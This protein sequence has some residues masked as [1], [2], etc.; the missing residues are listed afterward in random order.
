MNIELQTFYPANILV[1][2]DKPENVKLLSRL[3]TEQ[4]YKVR[5]VTNGEMALRAVQKMPP[6]LIL[7]DVKM[8]GLNGY[9]VCQRLK[10]IPEISQIPII[11][12][13]A[14]EDS[15]DKLKA[16]EAGGVD[17]IT[18]PFQLPEVLMRVQNQLKIQ[19][20]QT[21]IKLLN[22][23][24][25]EQVRQRT[26][27]LEQEIVKHEETQE[28]LRRMA[29]YDSLTGLPNRA[30]FLEL[31]H[32]AMEKVKRD[33][34]YLF[35]VLFLDCDRFKLINDSLG[36]FVGDQVLQE[37]AHRLKLCLRSVDTVARLGGDEFIILLEGLKKISDTEVI[38]NRIHQQLK[39]PLYL[40]EREI[41]M[42]ASIGIVLDTKDY[43]SPDM[44]LRD[45]DTAMYW[46]KKT[47]QNR[48]QIFKPEMHSQAQ[49]AL[50]LE[51]DL[52]LACKRDEFSLHYQPIVCLK[53]GSIQGFEALLRWNCPN[54]GFISPAT[55]IPIAEETG[56][57]IPIGMWA[58]RAA[59]LQLRAWQK[60][61]S[62]LQDLTMSVN[63]SVRQFSEPNLIQQ[64]DQILAE[65]GLESKFLKLEITESAIMDNSDSI[66]GTLEQLRNRKIE[67]SIDDFGTGYSSLSY[68][69]RFPV[70]HLKIDRSFIS[71]IEDNS[72]DNIRIV[73]TIITL[74]HHLNIKVVAEGIETEYQL[75]Q[76]RMLG[77][78]Y[79][80]GYFFSRPLDGISATELFK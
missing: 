31:L 44:I 47:G 77:C 33:R 28:Q 48:Y 53:T 61:N 26:A 65:T 4:G 16:F 3:L 49:Q 27:Q 10:S 41:F 18:K 71:Q 45:A 80:Q 54:R 46:A 55:F 30:F 50:E 9:Q 7:L 8:P 51:T 14:L 56:L 6:Q 12:L 35:S 60:Q 37:M 23:E 69:Y 2:D 25:E 59:C 5:G 58:L 1:V 70:D 24:L 79:G 57:I 36:H 76:L 72:E 39:F 13:S 63:F 11:F 38:A 17:Y 20:T 67:I 75:E 73:E 52:K 29:F 21:K 74:A 32:R 40:H 15:Q 43:Q 22:Q 19:S 42:S 66:T 78:E 62:A 64:I 68:L 34:N